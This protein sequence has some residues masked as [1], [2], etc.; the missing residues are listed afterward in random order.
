MIFLIFSLE[1]VH[2]W[3]MLGTGIVVSF[4]AYILA[5]NI[6]HSPHFLGQ[7]IGISS[8]FFQIFLCFTSDVIARDTC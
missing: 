6:R 3:V 4:D 5:K 2:G 1:F 8:G 7:N